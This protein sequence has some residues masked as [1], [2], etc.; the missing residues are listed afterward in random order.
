SRMATP[1]RK[2]SSTAVTGPAAAWVR[3]RLSSRTGAPAV[4]RSIRARWPARSASSSGLGC[5]RCSAATHY[6]RTGDAR[7]ARRSHRANTSVRLEQAAGPTWTLTKAPVGATIRGTGL[8]Q[9]TRQE[10]LRGPAHDQAL[11]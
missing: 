8:V 9:E 5:A 3:H 11:H 2:R 4:P 10:A 1:S 7:E 6:L